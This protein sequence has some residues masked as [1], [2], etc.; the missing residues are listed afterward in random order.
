M[1]PVF[2]EKLFRALTG[3]HSKRINKSKIKGK[4]MS[5]REEIVVGNWLKEKKVVKGW[6]CERVETNSCLIV[7][8][9]SNCWPTGKFSVC[10]SF[11][12]VFLFGLS[13]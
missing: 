7:A 5:K 13:F 3:R 12:C 4:E 8:A 9:V 6:T 1:A 10:R 11:S 2:F